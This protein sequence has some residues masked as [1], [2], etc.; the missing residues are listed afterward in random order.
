ML[1]STLKR[2]VALALVLTT[3]LITMPLTAAD[4]STQ[5]PMGSV[6]AVGSVQLRGLSISQEGTLFA[7]DIVRSGDKAYAK[8]LLRNGSKIELAEK[9]E[10]S[11]KPD[12]QGVLIAMNT[13]TV[14][15][16]A[17]SPLRIAVQPFE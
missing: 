15:F 11:V 10:V 1:G 7:G 9:T 6:S 3:T 5:K 16:T 2:I 12:N 14:G 4:L 17:A 8:V 13:G